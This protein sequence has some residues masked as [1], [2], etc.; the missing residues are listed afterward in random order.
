MG[1]DGHVASIFS[2]NLNLNISNICSPIIKKD[3][4]RITLNLKIINR[5][6]KISLWLNSKKKS[7]IY[8]KI[9]HKKNIPVNYLNKKV[10]TIFSL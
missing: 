7:A 8:K 4:K 5:S 1:S 2:N 9:N 3:F 6:K 10:L